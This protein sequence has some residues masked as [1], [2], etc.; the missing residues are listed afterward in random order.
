MAAQEIP[1]VAL[2]DHEASYRT[3]PNFYQAVSK[4]GEFLARKPIALG[5]GV[6]AVIGNRIILI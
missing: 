4:M 1:P 2:D 6:N 5:I 3:G